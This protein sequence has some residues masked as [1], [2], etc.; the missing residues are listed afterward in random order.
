MEIGY[1]MEKRILLLWVFV[2]LFITA[3]AEDTIKIK[4][5]RFVS[6]RI[7][8]G[9]V[10][11]TSNIAGGKTVVPHVTALDFKYGL[12][13]SGRNREDDYYGM[14]YRGIGFYKPFYSMWKEMGNPFSVYLFQGAALKTFRSERSLN[15][16]INLGV[17]FNW[18]HFDALDNPGFEALGSSVNVYVAGDLYYKRPLAENL[19]LNLGLNVTHFSNGAQR[20]PNYGINSVSPFVELVYH[21]D[22]RKPSSRIDGKRLPPPAFDE[23]T[24]HDVSFFV[25]ERTIS[26][27]TAGTDLRSRYPE[28]RFKVVGLNYSYMLHCERRFKWGA[29][30]D[31]LYDEGGGVSVDGDFSEK[32]GRYTEIVK[33]GSVPERISVGLSLKGELAMPGYAAFAHLGYDILHRGK[34]DSRLYQIYGIKVYLTKNLFSSFGV[35]S[36]HITRSRFLYIN[37]GYTFYKHRKN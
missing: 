21:I 36:T 3:S 24:A 16:E 22:R 7:A 11:P 25:T 31:V 1:R 20:T 6:L 28:Y 10:T 32:T 8:D 34:S 29:G 15:Y 37:I 23:R 2:C 13:A 14:P 27:D 12:S 9:L 19:D 33:F 30:V 17:S 26:V 18:K 35:N 5:P 4:R